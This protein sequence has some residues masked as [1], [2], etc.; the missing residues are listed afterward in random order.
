MKKLLCFALVLLL[1]CGAAYAETPF[2]TLFDAAKQLAFDTHNVTLSAEATF[3]YDGEV[4]KVMHAS[5]QQDGIRSFLSY[6]LD[7]PSIAGEMTTNG[8]IVLGTG[9]RAYSADKKYGYYHDDPT[10]TSDT[11]LTLDNRF[12]AQLNL[13]RLAALSVEEMVEETQNGNTYTF[14]AGDLPELI[15]NAVYYTLLDFVQDNYYTDLFHLYDYS[16]GEVMVRDEDW[17]GLVSSKYEALYNEP[18]P[19]ID[20]IFD[21]DTLFGRYSVAV[22]AASQAENEAA[23]EY[24]S[25]VVLIKADGS[26]EWFDSEASYMLA[27]GDLNVFYVSWADAFNNYYESL[28]GKRLTDEEIDYILY[29]PNEE[30][31]DAYS[32]FTDAMNEYYVNAARKQDEKA[33]SAVVMPDGTIKTYRYTVG[34]NKTVWM[35]ITGNM[36]FAEMKELNCEVST[37]DEGRLTA[38]KGDALIEITYKNDAK[39]TLKVEFDCAATGYGTTSVPETFEPEKY[40]VISYE[41]FAKKLDEEIEITDVAYDDHW[42]KII[43]NDPGQIEFAGKTYETM[44]NLYADTEN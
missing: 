5:Y 33:L 21:D 43:A 19:S 44:M 31:A 16:A 27:V 34:S 8:Y 1:L 26:V 23:A 17:M 13:A 11:I 40:D 28:Y 14:K 7:T 15:D 37:D 6:M 35:D 18:M 38:L 41:E 25:G 22:N 3:S 32:E 4:F 9:S 12:E 30:L 39:H 36:T 20:E 29:S 10:K 2:A 42:V 24:K